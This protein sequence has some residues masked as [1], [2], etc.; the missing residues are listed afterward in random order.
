MF[1]RPLTLIVAAVLA[2]QLL[3]AQD[4]TPAASGG[5][6][7]TKEQMAAIQQKLKKI[8]PTEYELEGMRINAATREIRIPT[9]VNIQRA[10]I[11]Y[12]LVHETGDKTHESILT[13][14]V[15]PIAIQVALLLANYQPAT[16]GMLANLGPEEER[17]KW[18]EAPPTTTGANRIS[19]TVEWQSNGETKRA[20]LSDWVQNIDTRKPPPDLLTWIFNG[21][22]IDE[23]GFA[24]Q[25]SGSIISVFIDLDTILNSPAKGCTRDELWISMPANIPPE[26]TSV[27][28]ILAPA[29]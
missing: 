18:K 8:S 22:R 25:T 6:A 26:G 9:L 11:E 15:P 4:P 28:L 24:A 21:S 5:S 12:A 20:P 1:C 2:F 16:E 17:P 19:A 3:G 10:P 29:A 23:R 7:T 13:T 27:T 14:K